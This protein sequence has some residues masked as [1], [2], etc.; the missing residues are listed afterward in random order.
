[1][2]VC[3]R[4][5]HFLIVLLLV[6]GMIGCSFLPHHQEPPKRALMQLQRQQQSQQA[7]KHRSQEPRNQALIAAINRTDTPTALTLIK[8]GADPNT[9]T[10]D[11]PP[12]LDDPALILAVQPSF[13]NSDRSGTPIKRGV[14]AAIARALLEHGA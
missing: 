13:R 11:S 4:H 8:A 6:C 10:G 1:M 2:K 7:L 12:Y 3:T 5:V 14:D 9:R